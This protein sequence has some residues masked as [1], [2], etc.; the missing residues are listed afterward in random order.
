MFTNINLIKQ[1]TGSTVLDPDELYHWWDFSD[2]STITTNNGDPITDGDFIHTVTDKCARANYVSNVG[3][4]DDT[5]WQDDGYS[6]FA[7]AKQQG[8]VAS[9]SGRSSVDILVVL[10]Y[11]ATTSTL[12]H[13]TF[14]GSNYIFARESGSFS[15]SGT[16]GGS[17]YV[18]NTIVS[19]DTAGSFYTDTNV[20]GKQLIET[21]GCDLD[22]ILTLGRYYPGY[23][24]TGKIYEIIV[25]ETTN[26]TYRSTIH[27]YFE[28]K[29]GLSL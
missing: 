12:F 6:D 23:F 13:D 17:I 29:Y 24:F 4:S 21:R 1:E 25:L 5:T 26:S 18:N 8:A 2:D 9:D 7:G 16:Q 27:T 19:P 14:G 22:M 11:T 10:E 15:G 28:E 20:A 3:T